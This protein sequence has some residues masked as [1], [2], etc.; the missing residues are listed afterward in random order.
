MVCC[1]KERTLSSEIYGVIDALLKDE[2]T[3]FDST[4]WNN[5]GC[6]TSYSDN[7][8]TLSYGTDYRYQPKYDI[9]DGL[10]LEFDINIPSTVTG[11]PQLYIKGFTP[12]FSQEWFPRDVW[13]HIK[14]TCQNGRC[15]L[16]SD[17]ELKIGGAYNTQNKNFQFRVTNSELTFKNFC[18]YPI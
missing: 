10:C 6:T 15:D 11:N 2:A 8:T 9:D 12:Y 16:Y 7:G 17:G 14:I 3:S 5:Y 13:H 18:I 1:N 4:K